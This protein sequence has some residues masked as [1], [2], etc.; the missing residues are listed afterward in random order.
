MGGRSWTAEEDIL[1]IFLASIRVTYRNIAG[2][3]K[4]KGFSRTEFGIQS[5]AQSLRETQNLGHAW[6]WDLGIVDKWLDK[7]AQ[8]YDIEYIL[9]P[10]PEEMN[11]MKANQPEVDLCFHYSLRMFHEQQTGEILE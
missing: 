11:F 9:V 5:R 1:L 10:T 8:E 2:L 3:F 4:L 6:Y 7:V